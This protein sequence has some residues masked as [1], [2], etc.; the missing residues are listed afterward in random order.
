VSERMKTT[1]SKELFE[2]VKAIHADVTN[3]GIFKYASGTI[4]SLWYRR[5][6]N[7]IL[8]VFFS[9]QASPDF[10]RQVCLGTVLCSGIS[11]T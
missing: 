10:I 5:R 11:C 7:R 3:V 8:F 6:L 9:S 1:N 2:G 4:W